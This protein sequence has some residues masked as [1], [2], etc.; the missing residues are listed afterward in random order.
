MD[1]T[2]VI[3]TLITVLL[4]GGV[5]SSIFFYRENKNKAKAEAKKEDASANVEDASAA[6]TLLNVLTGFKTYMESITSYNQN[7]NLK[8]LEDIRNKDKDIDEFKKEIA[9]LKL[10]VAE[11]DRKLSGLQKAFDLEVSARLEA[12]KYKCVVENCKLRQPPLKKQIA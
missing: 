7:V 5:V 1:W 12:E 10:K 6:N 3:V 4:T 9:S 11:N 8:L 2:T